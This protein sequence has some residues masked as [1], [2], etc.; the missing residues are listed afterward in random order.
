MVPGLYL[1]V[2][3]SGAKSWAVRYRLHGVTRK[4]TLGSAGIID[5]VMAR[6]KARRVLEAVAAG[7]D[8]ALLKRRNR[9]PG[10]ETFEVVARRFIERHLKPHNRSWQERER[11]LVTNVLPHWGPR[12]ISGLG[13]PDV[14]ALLDAI[15]DRGSPIMANRTF[16][17]VRRLFAWCIERGTLESSPCDRVKAPAPE[18]KRDRLHSDRELALVYRAADRLGYPYGRLVQVLALTGARREEVAGMRWGEINPDLTLWTLPK[19]RSKNGVQHEVPLA[20]AVSFILAGLPALRDRPRL[21][22]NRHRRDQGLLAIQAEARP[23]DCNLERRPHRGLAAARSPAHGGVRDGP[24]RGPPAGG[25][26]DPRTIRAPHL[27]ASLE[28]IS[29]TPSPRRSE[30]HWRFGRGTSQSCSHDPPQEHSAH[31]A[32]A[33]P[34]ASPFGFRQRAS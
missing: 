2:Q 25:R 13:R 17:V 18:V 1:I 24:A 20:P 8:P 4:L 16:G 6:T 12:P 15:V 10:I 34:F 30:R 7:D 23:D 3:P 19:G 21:H 27:P 31:R 22:I 29:G 26:E 14:V 11:I 5:L 28:S 33:S 9:E 32:P